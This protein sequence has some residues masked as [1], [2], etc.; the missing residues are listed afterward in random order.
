MMNT[1]LCANKL[2]RRC[3][4]RVLPLKLCT[5]ST[6]VRYTAL[7]SHPLLWRVAHECTRFGPIQLP[8]LIWAKQWSTAVKLPPTSSILQ[9]SVK[10]FGTS[11]SGCWPIPLNCR[12]VANA[13][14]ACKW[15]R[16]NV[17]NS[18]ST[19]IP[20]S[21]PSIACKRGRPLL[22]YF[23]FIFSYSCFIPPALSSVS[24]HIPF[25]HF[26][27]L[28]SLTLFRYSPCPRLFP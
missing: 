25:I 1:S 10:P 4:C 22:V 11:S 16:T 9:S 14:S 6:I 13:F 27:L 12:R 26:S 28:F 24:P 18:C 20:S 2:T 8:S 7:E 17:L 21:L 5:I 23:R 3:I 15:E 19:G